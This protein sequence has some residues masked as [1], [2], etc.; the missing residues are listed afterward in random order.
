MLF[1]LRPE[2][3]DVGKKSKNAMVITGGKKKKRTEQGEN[4]VKTDGK[5]YDAAGCSGRPVEVESDQPQ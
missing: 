3:E 2:G 5:R 4:E 1:H